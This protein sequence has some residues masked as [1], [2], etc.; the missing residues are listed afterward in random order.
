MIARSG[1]KTSSAFFVETHAGAM[2]LVDPVTTSAI[3]GRKA[4]RA[5]SPTKRPRPQDSP[6]P[7]R[8]RASPGCSAR[9]PAVLLPLKFFKTPPPYWI[10]A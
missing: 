3:T 2:R 1:S 10:S 9:G 8:A 6:E 4:P 7:P 5:A